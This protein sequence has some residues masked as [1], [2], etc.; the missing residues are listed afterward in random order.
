MYCT[1][2]SIYFVLLILH[3]HT[4][5][6]WHIRAPRGVLTEKVE[7]QAP[8]ASG[9]PSPPFKTLTIT[10]DKATVLNSCAYTVYIKSVP[11][12]LQG[13]CPDGGPLATIKS[14]ATW[15]EKASRCGN[16]NTALKVYGKNP[17]EYG[18][19]QQTNPVMQFEY[20]KT[21]NTMWYD[22]SFINCKD[23]PVESTSNDPGLHSCVGWKE[24]VQL[25]AGG[26]CRIA[27]C[28]PRGKCCKTSYCDPLGTAAR[29][30]TGNEPTLGCTPSEAGMAFDDM[31]LTAELCAGNL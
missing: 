23:T 24:G 16:G 26:G 1:T 27:K 17:E 2:V 19:D 6:T 25:G 7:R 20:G 3:A 10:P 14:G 21:D 28:A 9:G 29:V 11:G 5:Q 30:E 22:L 31:G 15:S 4:S 12:G 13:D 8:A 18:Y